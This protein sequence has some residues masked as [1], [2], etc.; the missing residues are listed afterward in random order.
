MLLGSWPGEESQGRQRLSLEA[1]RPV[2]I[3]Q[4]PWHG[5]KWP[6]SQAGPSLNSVNRTPAGTCR[7][8]LKTR[9]GILSLPSGETM[10]WLGSDSST[11][12]LTSSE[13]SPRITHPAGLTFT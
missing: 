4:G 13:T 12:A 5:R 2:G 8:E 7:A 10:T 1:A 9:A 3:Q 11:C 6:A